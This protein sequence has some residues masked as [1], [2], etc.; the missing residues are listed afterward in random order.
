V[1]VINGIQGTGKTTASRVLRGLIDPS[2]VMDSG[3]PRNES[4]A[5]LAASRSWVL[6][7]D[8]LSG[9]NNDLSD[10]VCR[11]ATGAGFRTRRLYS[12][13]EEHLVSIA[14]PVIMNGI[15]ELLRRDDLADRALPIK[16]MPIGGNR[17]TEDEYWK[18]FEVERPMLLGALLDVLAGVIRELPKAAIKSNRKPR[19]LGFSHLGIAA[20]KACSW[21]WGSFLEAY[22]ET[23]S[24]AAY[25]V[26]EGST[27]AQA[28][29]CFAEN[30]PHGSAFKPSEIRKQLVDIAKQDGLDATD[31][32][33]FN[34]R[35]FKGITERL[36]PPLLRC[37]GFSLK[38]RRTK[39]HNE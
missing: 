10:L 11:L 25:S 7:W 12:N 15:P 5:V 32:A 26:L 31:K 23:R 29:I 3:T 18:A 8:N 19:M 30:M 2:E 39:T 20:E 33:F 36:N 6:S 17:K 4:D 9:I 21:R 14:R 24:E 1:L 35:L 27:V 28:L 16:L 22:E 37:Y 13:H 38:W 34:D